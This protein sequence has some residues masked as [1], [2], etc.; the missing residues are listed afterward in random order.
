MARGIPCP[1]GLSLEIL[2]Q[3]RKSDPISLSHTK[4]LQQMLTIP[5]HVPGINP[6]WW[7]LKSA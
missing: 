5:A 2:Q 3:K 6:L 4:N 1:V 7:P